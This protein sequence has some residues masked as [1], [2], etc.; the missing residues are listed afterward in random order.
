MVSNGWCPVSLAITSGV[1]TLHLSDALCAEVSGPPCLLP[2]PVRTLLPPRSFKHAV[3]LRQIPGR[4]ADSSRFYHSWESEDFKNIILSEMFCDL[5]CQRQD[6][7]QCI[8]ET[9][10]A[11]VMC[12]LSEMTQS[13]QVTRLQQHRQ[14]SSG[15]PLTR[16]SRI[17]S[18]QSIVGTPE[19]QRRACLEKRQKDKGQLGSSLVGLLSERL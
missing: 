15:R 1:R 18:L 2:V 8:L 9:L 19:V 17:E 5:Y 7:S 11:L 10:Y 13:F 16:I 12:N 6:D 14:P 4:G 3:S